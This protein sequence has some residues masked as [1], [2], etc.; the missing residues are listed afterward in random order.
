MNVIVSVKMSQASGRKC[1]CEG[2]RERLSRVFRDKK[3][4]VQKPRGF[5]KRPL[6]VSLPRPPAVKKFLSYERQK[7][8]K[9]EEDAS[10]FLPFSSLF[11]S[12]IVATFP[13]ENLTAPGLI[14]TSSTPSPAC[15]SPLSAHPP[16]HLSHF[17]SHLR[18]SHSIALTFLPFAPRLLFA[19]S[20]F[21][22]HSVL[23]SHSRTRA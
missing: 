19:S 17:P 1:H 21:P 13:V 20:W 2:G 6:S 11:T 22:L 18:F 12:P 16:T 3:R 15:L 23:I 9:K 5:E 7:E 8:K 10:L 14:D 4:K